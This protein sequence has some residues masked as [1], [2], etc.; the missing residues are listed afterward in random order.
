S[1]NTISD[2]GGIIKDY[3]FS[4]QGQANCIRN[5]TD[6]VVNRTPN[7]IGVCYWEGGWITVGGNSREENLE[8]WEKFG[9][10][11]ASSHA[12]V[13]DPEDAGKYYGGSAVDNQ[14]F[15]DAEGKPLESLKVFRLMRTGNETEPVPDALEEPTVLCDLNL[16]LSLPETVD[17]IMT[18]DSR[19]PVQ[20]TWNVTAEKD[21]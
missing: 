18:D 2:G 4:P 8:K 7:G 20:V 14:A 15:F 17:A 5:I 11:W 1:G 3:P 10:G 6:T 12:A 9:S 19:Q 16:P 13:Y 21:A